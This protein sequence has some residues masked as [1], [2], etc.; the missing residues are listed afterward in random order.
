MSSKAYYYKHKE[1]I[2]AQQRMNYARKKAEQGETVRKAKSK[3]K[4][5]KCNMDCFN[6]IYPDCIR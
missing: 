2:T 4:K 3:P 6:C 1:Q 5:E